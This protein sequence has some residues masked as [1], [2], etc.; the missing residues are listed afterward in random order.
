MQTTHDQLA[1]LIRTRGLRHVLSCLLNAVET[2]GMER[3]E[4]AK[5]KSS[6]LT[7]QDRADLIGDWSRTFNAVK[8]VATSEEVVRL[9]KTN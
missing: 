2:V 3:V 9:S 5:D 8:T 7:N 1:K 4:L 6:G